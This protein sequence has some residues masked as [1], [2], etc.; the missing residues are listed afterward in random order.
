[1]LP[2]VLEKLESQFQE[3]KTC[4]LKF[5]LKLYLGICMLIFFNLIS[6]K[7]AVVHTGEY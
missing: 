2:W 5:V 6:G 3:L 1:M 4:E 7:I